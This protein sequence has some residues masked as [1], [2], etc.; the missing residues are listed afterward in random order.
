MKSS[1]VGHDSC[2]VHLEGRHSGSPATP[3][4]PGAELGG[5][6]C[7]PYRSDCLG[8]RGSDRGQRT[9]RRGRLGLQ[10]PGVTLRAV[11]VP[12][13][14]VLG[15]GKP[16]LQPCLLRARTVSSNSM[17]SLDLNSKN[18][19]I[20]I[21]KRIEFIHAFAVIPFPPN[22]QNWDTW[23]MEDRLKIF[24]RLAPRVRVDR[25]G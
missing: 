20:G 7:P 9:P 12:T 22:A 5:E 23:E 19:K 10:S 17:F 8:I 18:I 6:A 15:M 1:H 25:G 21:P 4:Y 16:M 14:P 24:A 2:L 3:Q 11:R 13:T